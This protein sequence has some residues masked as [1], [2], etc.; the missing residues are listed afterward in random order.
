[1]DRSRLQG[2]S[3]FPS[4]FLFTLHFGLHRSVVVRRRSATAWH[5]PRVMQSGVAKGPQSYTR[6]ELMSR[7]KSSAS[8]RSCKTSLQRRRVPRRSRWQGRKCGVSVG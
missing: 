1:V 8:S 5:A 7:R 3:F 6:A 2:M 4:L